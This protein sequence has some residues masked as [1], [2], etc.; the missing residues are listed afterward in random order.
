MANGTADQ[1][2]RYPNG[3]KL[4]APAASVG[5]MSVR[6]LAS[7][8]PSAARTKITNPTNAMAVMTNMIFSASPA[9]VR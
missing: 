9:P 8:L 1:I 3:R 4:D 6:L 5:A 7:N 2:P